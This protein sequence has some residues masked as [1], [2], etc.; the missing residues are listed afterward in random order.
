MIEEELIQKHGI[1]PDFQE[2]Y[3]DEDQRKDNEE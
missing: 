3:W 2:W 1:H